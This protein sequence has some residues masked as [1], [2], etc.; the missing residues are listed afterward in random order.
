MA[1]ILATDR[2]GHWWPWWLKIFFCKR[3]FS[4]PP[5]LSLIVFLV[6][7]RWDLDMTAVTHVSLA[8][9][10]YTQAALGCRWCSSSS[11]CTP[12]GSCTRALTAFTSI[13]HFSSIFPVCWKCF[14][15]FLWPRT[16]FNYLGQNPIGYLKRSGW[17]ARLLFP[18]R[19][20]YQFFRYGWNF[21]DMAGGSGSW[22]HGGKIRY[23]MG[24][25]SASFNGWEVLGDLRSS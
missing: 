7:I 21:A 3:I 16:C 6:T 24:K 20:L 2:C 15:N 5:F 9:K 23:P 25:S 10:K 8:T 4:R 19:T 17:T 14:L 12:Y 13:F 11:H 18:F 22:F 1:W